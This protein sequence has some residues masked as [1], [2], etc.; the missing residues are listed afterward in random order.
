MD[1]TDQYTMYAMSEIRV[2]SGLNSISMLRPNAQSL[3]HQLHTEYIS[4]MSEK[5]LF[6]SQ[7]FD[8]SVA[9]VFRQAKRDFGKTDCESRWVKLLIASRRIA[10]V[11]PD[12][13]TKNT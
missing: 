13:L 3:V 11:P 2:L 1:S 5:F 8:V 9:T 7:S 6:Q 10:R 4:K 12:Y